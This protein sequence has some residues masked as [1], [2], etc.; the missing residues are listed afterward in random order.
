MII[1]LLL[2]IPSWTTYISRLPFNGE[3]MKEY[4]E[5]FSRSYNDA[6]KLKQYIY[7]LAISEKQKDDIWEQ[8]VFFC[9][10]LNKCEWY[11]RRVV[12]C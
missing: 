8:I 7:S 10:E 5:T 12:R 1:E 3:I 11:Q 9:I 6:R 4:I 2:S